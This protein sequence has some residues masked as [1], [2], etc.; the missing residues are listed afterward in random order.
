MKTRGLFLSAL[1]MGA[2]MAGCSNEEVMNE[3]FQKPDGNEYYMAV[4]FFTSET[5]R[6]AEGDFAAAS[7]AETD[8]NNAVFYFLDENG[9]SC[10]DPY[11]HGELTLVASTRIQQE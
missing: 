2:V 4:N 1:L 10:A 11:K 8:V 3:E 6:R 5:G 9:N 7:D